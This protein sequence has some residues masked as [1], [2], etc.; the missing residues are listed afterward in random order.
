[1][2]TIEKRSGAYRVKVRRKGYPTVTASFDTKGQAEEFARKVEHD[3]DERRYRRVHRGTLGELFARYATEVSPSKKGVR[4]EQVRLKRLSRELGHIPLPDTQRDAVW[5]RKWRD[6][7]L[8]TVA[9]SSVDRELTLI[10]SVF[11]Y[12]MKEWEM[13]L[14]NPVRL[15]QRP[16]SP[17]H[18]TVRMDDQFIAE[19]LTKT[20]Y[21]EGVV[22]QSKKSYVPYVFL[23]ALETA[24][25][26]GELLRLTWDNVH[27]EESWC[28][29]P[30]TKNGTD[31]NVP[32]TPRAVELLR[33]LPR[34][35]AR[36]LPI[37]PATFDV[38]W[39]RVRPPGYRFHDSRHEA[40]TRLAA[41]LPNVLELSAVTGHRDLRSLRIYFNPTPQ[42]LA[43]KIAGVGPALARETGAA[44]ATPEP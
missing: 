9:G 29:L 41:A 21:V 11:S 32:L 43:A 26:S 39:R 42:E 18:R 3:M 1:M 19:I 36:V 2:A 30:D 24:M 13:P 17:P 25:R 40:T 44:P 33:M 10:S 27:L 16:K 22:P 5:L 4:W 35:D 38:Y 23:L 37:N 31:R 28:Y 6:A 15:V 12:A 14:D 20:G 7:R 8:K 34:T